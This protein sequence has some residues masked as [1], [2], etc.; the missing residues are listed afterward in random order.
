MTR[1]QLARILEYTFNFEKDPWIGRIV[2]LAILLIVFAICA[3]KVLRD[4]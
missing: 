3:I 1:E 4:K 2:F